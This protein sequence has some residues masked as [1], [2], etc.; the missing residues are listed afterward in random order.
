MNRLKDL[1]REQ[2]TRKLLTAQEFN[3]GYLK[4]SKI[5]SMPRLLFRAVDYW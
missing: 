4:T 1:Y 5:K 2:N 3:V